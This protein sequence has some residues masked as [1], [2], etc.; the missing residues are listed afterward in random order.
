MRQVQIYL[1]FT[2]KFLRMSIK[3][4]AKSCLTLLIK[5]KSLS[6]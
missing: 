6:I 1:N 2:Y 4:S 5:I 3:D